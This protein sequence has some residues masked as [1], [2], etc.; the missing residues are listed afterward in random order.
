MAKQHIGLKMKTVSQIIE[1]IRNTAGSN[2]KLAIMMDNKGDELLQRVFKMTYDP[3]IRFW[4]KGDRFTLFNHG[5]DYTLSE[6]L[7]MIFEKIVSRELTGNMSAEYIEMILNGIPSEDQTVVINMLDKDQR[8]GVS[9]ATINKVWPKLIPTMT[10]MKCADS[11][12]DQKAV[13]MI[14]FPCFVQRKV[15]AARCIGVKQLDGEVVMLSS[16]GNPFQGLTKLYA[17]LDKLTPGTVID[18]EL[19]QKGLDRKKSNGIANKSI[20][21]TISKAEADNFEFIV[22]DCIP[23]DVYFNKKSYDVPYETRLIDLKAKAELFDSDTIRVVE[24]FEVEDAAEADKIL[25]SYWDQGEEGTIVKRKDGPW[26]AKRSRYAVKYKE[27]KEADFEIT[28]LEI[29]S[30]KNAN[31]LGNILFKTADGAIESSVGSG[32]TD[33]ERDEYWNRRE[34]LVGKIITVR[35]NMRVDNS[36]FLPRFVEIRFDKKVADTNDKV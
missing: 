32:F 13:E 10:L 27:V 3:F 22:W 23:E 28:A 20:K 29:G 5:D 21:G 36:L 35:Y 16:G 30:G 33:E 12:K 17:E 1:E 24:T 34:E 9:V 31:R 8:C 11:S 18:G 2:D 19:L 15:D 25:Q 4:I 26:E 6:S 14:Q 7:D